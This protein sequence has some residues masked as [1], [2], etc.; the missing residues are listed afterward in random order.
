M[1][2]T[3][4]A[5]LR[6]LLDYSPVIRCMDA[7]P[8]RCGSTMAP[9]SSAPTGSRYSVNP[10]R[11]PSLGMNSGL[12]WSSSRPA[13]T[14]VSDKASAHL[15][16]GATRVVISAPSPD[17]DATLVVGVNEEQFDPERHFIISNASCTT[18]CL[19]VLAKVLDDAFGIED[20]FMT[21]V[22]A[23]TGDQSLVDTLHKDP[24]RSRGAAIN[25]V[26]TTTGA[27]RATGLVLPSVAGTL[28]GLALRV[29]V[30]DAS[31]TDLVAN[32]R[33]TPT[34]TEIKDAYQAAAESG[35][36][37]G[38][39]RVLG[40]TPR[41]FRHRRVALLVRLRLGAHHGPRAPRQ[42]A[43]LVRQRVGLCQSTRRPGGHR[44]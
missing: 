27:A 33:A 26:P 19:A 18:N 25:I 43:R 16:A 12:T 29:P 9:W 4:S 42:G 30:P 1:R 39:S 24:R 5:P 31:I 21:T 8:R 44:R 20:G 17:A 7:F 15:E 41:L 22:H 34:V 10:S 6:R 13:G 3:I 38:T 28:D 32:V 37:S 40:R 23:Y 35:R 36:L 11:R 2:S 14:P